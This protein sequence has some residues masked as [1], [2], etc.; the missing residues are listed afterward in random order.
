MYVPVGN[1]TET[2]LIRFL[3][4]AEIPV[5]EI[6]KRKLNKIQT[7]IPFSSIRKR[8]VVAMHL[9]DTDMVRIYVK[10]APEVVLHKCVKTFAVDGS[11]SHLTDEEINY[12]SQDVIYK[13]FTSKGLRTLAF[14]YK[15]MSLDEFND[16]KERCNGFAEEQDRDVLEQNL[17]FIGVFA[18]EDDLRDKVLR[19]VQYARKGNLTVRMVSGD[20]LETAKQVAI[21]AGIVTEEEASKNRYTCMSAE[22]FRKLVGE[23]RRERDNEGNFRLSI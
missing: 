15:D 12:I 2:G 16:I 11:K 20:N 17:I 7:T 14:G 9:P 18:L 3:Q 19:S 13:Q 8:S 10:G 4:D 21:K 23:L 5:H 22:E 1:G 6:I